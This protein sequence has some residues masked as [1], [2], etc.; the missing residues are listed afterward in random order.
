LAITSPTQGSGACSKAR[1]RRYFAS[2]YLGA[3]HGALDAATAYAKTH[4]RPAPG[5]ESARKDPYIL[6]L[7]GEFWTQV[8]AAS[9]FFYKVAAEMQDG[10]KRRRTIGSRER[11]WLGV[12]ANAVRAFVT[13]VGLD[14]T[15]RIYE[16]TGDR[17]THND[18]GFDRFWR[19]IRTHS[20]RDNQHYKLRSIGDFALNDE[21]YEPPS[22][23]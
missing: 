19:D 1:P 16:T 14:V 23:A 21:A 13:K 20:L 6:H 5:V 10:F 3:I 11:A 15:P 17:A 2:Y 4:G 18:F 9:A 12:R 8:E 7:Y 22:F